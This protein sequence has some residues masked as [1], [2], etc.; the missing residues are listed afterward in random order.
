MACVVERKEEAGLSASTKWVSW[1]PG[2]QAWYLML[3]SASQSNWFSFIYSDM[4]K[5][6]NSILLV[7][8]LGALF[9][10]SD[11]ILQFAIL[12]RKFIEEFFK[13]KIQISVVV[14]K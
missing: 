4:S 8:I 12:Q 9:C 6:Y 11:K 14:G 13:L 7:L 5:L 10:C 1:I 2:N 3:F